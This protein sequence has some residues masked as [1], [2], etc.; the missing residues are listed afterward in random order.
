MYLLQT[1]PAFQKKIQTLMQYQSEFTQEELHSKSKLQQAQAENSSS[2]STGGLFVSNVEISEL[3]ADISVIMLRLLIE[4]E[5]IFSRWRFA[6]HSILE[7]ADILITNGNFHLAKIYL[8]AALDGTVVSPDSVLSRSLTLQVMGTMTLWGQLRVCT[9]RKLLLCHR[10][11]KDGYNF[12]LVSLS[13][14]DPA[15]QNFISGEFRQ[16]LQHNV[17]EVVVKSPLVTDVQ[18]HFQLHV[19]LKPPPEDMEGGHKLC[20]TMTMTKN[21]KKYIRDEIFDV[22]NWL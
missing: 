22:S 14:L 10:A 16:H 15:L 4:N 18:Y 7:S 2:R 19:Q 20:P 6:C 13:L 17:M 1:I 11:L 21:T 8:R 9:L 5:E 3:E 12:I